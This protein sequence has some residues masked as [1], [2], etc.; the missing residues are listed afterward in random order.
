MAD[1]AELSLPA[2][3]TATPPD[4][5][6]ALPAEGTATPPAAEPSPSSPTA[7]AVAPPRNPARSS[8][9]DA[10]AA[11]HDDG[12]QRHGAALRYS[13][14]LLAY[15]YAAQGRRNPAQEAI[16][17]LVTDRFDILDTPQFGLYAPK[18]QGAAVANAG[19]RIMDA[20]NAESVAD[21]V[22][23]GGAGSTEA[24]RRADYA[25]QARGGRW[26][27]DIT[28]RHAILRDAQGR[29]VLAGS[30]IS[31]VRLKGVPVVGFVMA[32]ADQ[33][34]PIGDEA[35][36]RGVLSAGEFDLAQAARDPRR[37]AVDARRDDGLPDP[38]LIEVGPVRG[39]A[40]PAD[41]AATS[42]PPKSINIYIEGLKAPLIGGAVRKFIDR[43]EP[44]ARHFY[45]S[46]TEDILEF[47][48]N[49]PPG[50]KI[51]L[52]GHSYGADTAAV[53]A[54]RSERRIENLITID[55][56]SRRGA[57]SDEGPNYAQVKS[58]VNWWHNVNSASPRRSI[59]ESR[60]AGDLL[61]WLGGSWEERHRTFTDSFVT[62]TA[63][64]PDFA[65]MMAAE[66]NGKSG[67]RLI[68]P[69]GHDLVPK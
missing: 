27:M 43:R 67:N 64:H 28:G 25:E 47:I 10:F 31:R 37:E 23:A 41:S 50:T 24:Q 66:V 19:L 21:P 33:V 62:A 68:F 69:I 54:A 56:V 13:V 1:D 49:L 34:Q 9:G 59:D 11:L 18:G 5:D 63:D 45:Q 30:N 35:D 26:V 65:A 2:E 44:G 36:A 46:Q 39:H 48:R 32:Q 12:P 57:G 53:V 16:R 40:K 6:P 3:G 8:F 7:A 42:G 60:P 17:M 20:L 15:Y 58:N 38:P 14:E 22:W 52:I 29:S 51:N 4:A 61:A 55:P